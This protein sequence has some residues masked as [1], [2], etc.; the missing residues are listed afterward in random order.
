MSTENAAVA[1]LSSPLV[2]SKCRDAAGVA[3]GALET[4]VAAV[5]AGKSVLELCKLGD[6]TIT[7]KL[8]SMYSKGK[9]A[10]GIAFPTCISLNNVAGHVN[11][12]SSDVP[13]LLKEGDVVKVDL[14]AHIDGFVAVAAHTVVVGSASSPLP[15][16]Q[17]DAIL[18]AYY[19]SLVASE[20]VR[21][22]AKNADVTRVINAVADYFGVSVCE[23]VLSHQMKQY[24][25][26]ANK[27]I[28]GK[29]TPEQRVEEYT[30]EPN[31]VYA[32]DVVVSSGEGKLR[33]SD[34]R[35][36]IYKRAV[37]N[38]YSLKGSNAKTVFTAINTHFPTFPFT[39]RNFE[40]PKSKMGLKEIVEHG[41]LH[42]YPV[43]Q[44]KPAEIVAQFKTTVFVLPKGSV[45]ATGLSAPNL[46]GV[47]GSKSI[48]DIDNAE[49][50]E[51]LANASKKKT[52][53]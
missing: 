48:D 53:K 51:L 21:A 34:M 46:H 9:F 31:E 36:T 24:V 19:G 8:K 50:K 15:Q 4:V 7:E 22:G 18:A 52:K 32:V 25:I 43:L 1:D 6:D 28:L 11:P 47:T 13:S 44:E 12:L 5:A 49:V 16:K 2:E 42:P 37:E 41:L 26:D 40:D 27:V 17:A 39:T 35:T 30:F 23:G 14:G 33:Q 45:K 38:M 20:A 3:Q 10:K 29:P